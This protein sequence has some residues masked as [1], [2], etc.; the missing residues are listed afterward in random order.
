MKTLISSIIA[1]VVIFSA[2]FGVKFFLEEHKPEADKKERVVTTPVVEVTI[3]KKQDLEFPL[4]S[5]GV[6]MTR[7]ETILS[8]QV[9]GRI[10]DIHPQ[11]E[12]G[13]TFK[14]GEVIAKIDRLDYEAVIAQAKSV[15]A[16]AE[17]AVL[18]EKARGEQAERDWKKIGGGKKASDLVLRIPFLKSTKARLAAAKAALEKAVEDLDRTE[19]RAPFDC[20]VR[21]VVLNLGATVAPGSQL[22]TIYDA[23]NLMVRLPFSIDDYA[24]I[25]KDPGINL[26]ADVGAET[27]QWVGKVMWDLGEVD[28]ATVSAYLL[29]KVLP[30][31]DA[32]ERFRLPTPG[33]F[34]K[35]RLTGSTL[36]NVVAVPRSAVRGRDRVGILNDKGELEFRTLVIA[37]GSED[38]V[39]ATQGVLDG[40][41]V[42]LTKIELPIEG[43]KLAELKP[44]ERSGE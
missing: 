18:Q 6:V 5:E 11:F 36:S 26:S 35:A 42:I 37:R 1:I 2:T 43:M 10:V 30:N 20:R 19:I 23:E 39:Y 44:G 17:L 24:Q 7:R 28:Q 4:K 13:A 32:P 38:F 25:P 3:V 8:A 14:K 33:L 21:T 34:L 31:K 9:G 16:D 12:L 40:E 27:Y 22:G 41:K 15:L 29:A